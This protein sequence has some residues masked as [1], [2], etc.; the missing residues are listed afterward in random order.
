MNGKFDGVGTR[1]D[2]MGKFL[3]KCYWDQD[4]IKNLCMTE[5]Y[6]ERGWDL[7]DYLGNELCYVGEV[8]GGG[9]PGG[10][11]TSWNKING[12]KSYEGFWVDGKAEGV[13]KEYYGGVR[14]GASLL[15]CG[16]VSEGKA[17]G[18]GINYS[19]GGKME[20]LGEYRG[21]VRDGLRFNVK[22]NET[23]EIV[24]YEPGVRSLSEFFSEG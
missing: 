23:G 12:G 13:G 19:Y 3:V 20:Y 7:I 1:F 18:Y 11:G 8:G 15:F 14:G 16:G 24:E 22:F 17:N 6:Y 21:N 2:P 9:K 4:H 10:F 5:R